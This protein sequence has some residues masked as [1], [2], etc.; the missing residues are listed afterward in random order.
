[1]KKTLTK[2]SHRVAK[3]SLKAFIF[4]CCFSILTACQK[5]SEGD[6]IS[7]KA[8]VYIKGAEILQERVIEPWND[9][10]TLSFNFSGAYTGVENLYQQAPNDIDITFKVDL[11]KVESYNASNGTNYQPLPVAS[12][13]STSFSS[14]IAQNAQETPEMSITVD[15]TEGLIPLTEY[16]LPI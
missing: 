9:G 13:S 8:I 11:E 2:N 16:L 12:V 7:S 10:N 1:M 14:K 3:Q 6:T 15:V 5:N 4:L